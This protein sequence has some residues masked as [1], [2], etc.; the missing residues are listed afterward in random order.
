[1]ALWAKTGG[2]ATINFNIPSVINYATV[3]RIGT[4]LSFKGDRPTPSIIAL[5]P[6]P[7]QDP[8]YSS[9]PVNTLTL[10]VFESGDSGYLSANYIIDAIEL[11]NPQGTGG[12]T[13]VVT[14]TSSATATPTSV[15]AQGA[16]YSQCGGIGVDRTYDVCAGVSVPVFE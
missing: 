10:G 11:Q 13:S 14:R 3:L 7:T 5:G 1:M 15:G 4:T 12:A 2:T 9:H 16:L 6:A 8:Q